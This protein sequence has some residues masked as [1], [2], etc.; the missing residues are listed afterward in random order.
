WIPSVWRREAQHHPEPEIAQIAAATPQPSEHRP[1]PGAIPKKRRAASV[2]RPPPHDVLAEAE[3]LLAPPAPVRTALSG[4][5]VV[6][7]Q[8]QDPT[9]TIVLLA[10]NTGDTE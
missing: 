8:T 10:G 4:P 3:A 7:M 5:V 6:E 2:K 9:V 1:R